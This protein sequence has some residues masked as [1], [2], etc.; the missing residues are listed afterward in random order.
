MHTCTQLQNF[1][2]LFFIDCPPWNERKQWTKIGFRWDSIP[3][4][5]MTSMESLF[6]YDHMMI[7]EMQKLSVVSSSKKLPFYWTSLSNIS[8]DLLVNVYIKK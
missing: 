5:I 6:Q 7:D 4:Q 8:K 3:L 2:L 1:G